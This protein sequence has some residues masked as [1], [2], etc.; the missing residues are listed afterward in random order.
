MRRVGSAANLWRRI[1]K[2]VWLW[3]QSH[4]KQCL[5]AISCG[6]GA[7][8]RGRLLT[9]HSCSD[10]VCHR[11][12]IQ[13]RL[14]CRPKV[15][16]G[17][18]PMK[19]R[20]GQRALAIAAFGLYMT[21]SA[22][23]AAADTASEIRALK[24]RLSKLEADE[25]RARREAKVAAQHAALPADKGPPPPPPPLHWYERLSL[26]GYTQM[27]YNDILS[28]GPV[29]QRRQPRRTIVRSDDARTSSFV[30]LASF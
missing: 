21:A 1:R 24:A 23:P 11:S 28:G 13:R 9:S 17:I 18:N 19:L 26:R 20:V 25:A 6:V 29:L 5:G 14:H 8:A 30:A 16:R 15:N 7:T 22:A 12:V 10:R 27:R 4:K 2:K 3:R